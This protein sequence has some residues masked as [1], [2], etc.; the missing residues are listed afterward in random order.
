MGVVAV[1]AMALLLR[2]LVGPPAPCTVVTV[3]PSRAPR[4]GSLHDRVSFN[5]VSAAPRLRLRG[6]RWSRTALRAQD[7]ESCWRADPSG[8]LQQAL[9][10]ADAEW[11]ILQ[12]QAEDSEESEGPGARGS[13]KSARA[14][15]AAEL[16]EGSALDR[17]RPYV[18]PAEYID[19]PPLR[20]SNDALDS[21]LQ[22]DAPLVAN[23]LSKAGTLGGAG[24]A[25]WQA[26][27]Y[28]R[29]LQETPGEEPVEQAAREA[30]EQ[31]DQ[32]STAF[33]QT[34]RGSVLLARQNFVSAARF[35]YFLRRG[36][37]RWQLEREVGGLGA[38]A[39]P[40]DDFLAALQRK[41]REFGGGG[42]AQRTLQTLEGYLAKLTTEQ[43]VELARFATEEA[44]S[45]LERRATT[46][47]GCERELLAEFERWTSGRASQEVAQLTLSSESRGRLSEEAAAFGAALFEAEEAAARRYSLEYTAFG[48]RLSGPLR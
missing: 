27:L 12:A 34:L 25:F 16:L 43:A 48:S 17:L 3:G 42:N 36:R 47:F 24:I 31:L 46:L 10:R 5:D 6:V 35:G 21:L 41:A 20:G 32:E 22:E 13:A 11:A 18:V 39:D 15:R 40:E 14:D 4:A 1:V 29:K 44:T 8:A 45:A 30:G 26:E 38:E 9:G 19:I 28:L 37:R 33:R 23:F 7:E 2:L